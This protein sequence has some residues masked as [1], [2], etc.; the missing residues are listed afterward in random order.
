MRLINKLLKMPFNRF[1]P[2]VYVG[3]SPHIGEGTY[4][5]LFSEINTKGGHVFIGKDCDIASFVSINAADSHLRCIGFSENISRGRIILGDNVFVGSHSFIGGNVEI[6][7]H[8]VIAAHT[9]LIVDG[10][11]IPPYSL[12]C[13]NPHTIKPGYYFNRNVKPIPPEIKEIGEGERL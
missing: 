7:H 4:V 5:G 11:I 6:G 10:L 9:C 1:H 13:G 3:D 12:I 8:S 2:L